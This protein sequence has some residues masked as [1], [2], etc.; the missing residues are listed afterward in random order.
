MFIYILAVGNIK[1]KKRKLMTNT[2]N[3]SSQ[4]RQNVRSE[5]NIV[6]TFSGTAGGASTKRVRFTVPYMESNAAEKIGMHELHC[7]MKC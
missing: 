7:Y 6:G 4:E 5:E 2:I 1:P 3:D